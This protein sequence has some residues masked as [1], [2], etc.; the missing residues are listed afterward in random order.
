MCLSVCEQI[1]YPVHVYGKLCVKSVRNVRPI[2]VFFCESRSMVKVKAEFAAVYA[3]SE[4][5]FSYI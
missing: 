5:L 2:E 3:L 1:K 4:G